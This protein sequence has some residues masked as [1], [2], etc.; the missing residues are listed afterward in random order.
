MKTTLLFGV[1]LFLLAGSGTAWG[2]SPAGTNLAQVTDY[3]AEYPFINRFKQARAWI[4]GNDQTFTFDD[5]RALDLDA[6]DDVRSLLSDQVAR[7]VLFTGLPAD[8]GLANKRMVLRYAGE[9]SLR[10]DGRVE[11]LSQQPGRDVIRLLGGD[12]RTEATLIITL[13]STNPDNPLRSIRLTPSGGVCASKPR[14]VVGSAA[15]CADGEYRSFERYQATLRFDPLF[16]SR[17]SGYGSLRFMD[18]MRT[19]NSAQQAFADR[20]RVADAFWSTDAGVPLEVM[21]DLANRLNANPWFNIPHLASDDYVRRFA[22]VVRD[23]LE[24][25]RVAWFEYSNEVWNS[26]F[27]QTGYATD[28]GEE[29]GFDQPENDTT[30]GML[31]YY[32]DR[33]QAVFRLI[34]EEFGGTARIRRVLATQ[35]VIPFFTQTILDHEDAVALTDAFAIAPYFGVSVADE[36]DA[37]EIK[38]LGVDGLFIWLEQDNNAELDYGSLASIE[39]TI[40]DQ[41]AELDGT[42]IPLVSYEGGQHFVG[43]FGFENDTDLNRILTLVNRDARMKGI[44]LRYLR[45]W[46]ARTGQPFMHFVHCDRWSRYGRWGA[47]QFPTQARS[48]AP[49]FDALRT[50][51]EQNPLP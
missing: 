38:A 25:G 7:T 36:A 50:F 43:V 27:E 44:Y 32:S 46:Q 17:L 29:L 3:T 12:A 51:V 47:L 48:R 22:R 34:E 6:N 14:V 18:W 42:G 15:D 37:A 20:P 30:I 41:L 49:K 9:G 8:P 26:I 24:P 11:V 19:N 4:S 33:A 16:L 21:I 31:R 10:Y 5:G 40:D 23:R 2:A 39:R 45:D 28:R 35:A 1:L 13:Q